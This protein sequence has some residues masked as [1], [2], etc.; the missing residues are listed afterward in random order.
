MITNKKFYLIMRIT[1]KIAGV[2]CRQRHRK[3]YNMVNKA[4][5][6]G[7]LFLMFSVN[8]FSQ[9]KLKRSKDELNENY[10]YQSEYRT[11]SS[12]YS[13][14]SNNDEDSWLAEVF[15][16]IFVFA[17]FGKY[18]SEDHLHNLYT[19]YPYFYEN[20]GNYKNEFQYDEVSSTRFTIENN[21]YPVM[22]KVFANRLKGKINFRYFGFQGDWL[23][24]QEIQG[25]S[26]AIFNLSFCYDRLRF[27]R[28]NWGWNIGANFVGT[29]VNKFGFSIGT[30]AEAFI[31]NPVSLYASAKWSW[32]NN[33][34]VSQYEIR[35]KHYINRY[36]ISGG[37]ELIR[38]ASP[39][40]N[41]I[42]LGGGVCF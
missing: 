41:Y 2:V 11:S 9:G 37:I 12:S 18:D 30:D 5:S 39:R 23:Q 20:K 26:L 16:Y 21:I 13:S 42:T 6:I 33:Q 27:E 14:S 22:Q 24:M 35:M 31:F 8:G 7:L 19:P 32:V 3:N 4:F 36:Y 1:K 10:Q 38:A 25:A 34:P 17:F 40:Y 28:F 29:G 15:S